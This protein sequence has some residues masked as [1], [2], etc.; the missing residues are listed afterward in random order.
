MNNLYLKLGLVYYQECI[1]HLKYESIC[2]NWQ[3]VNKST[4]VIERLGIIR[5]TNSFKTR[6]DVYCTCEQAYKRFH[7]ILSF[8]AARC[9]KYYKF[10]SYK[11]H[12]TGENMGHTTSNVKSL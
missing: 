7:E 6:H 9:H 5:A 1:D 11:C 8:S 2:S 12:E 10:S 4:F 3:G